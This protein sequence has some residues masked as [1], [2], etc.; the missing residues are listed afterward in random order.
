MIHFSSFV[1]LVHLRIVNSTKKQLPSVDNIA[2]AQ[3]LHI[4]LDHEETLLVAKMSNI[5]LRPKGKQFVRT[6]SAPNLLAKTAASI[7]HGGNEREKESN[8]PR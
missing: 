8:T 5:R 4:L 3:M 6:Q 2:S 7:E 1:T